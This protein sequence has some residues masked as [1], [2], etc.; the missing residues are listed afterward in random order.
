VQVSQRQRR[1]DRNGAIAAGTIACARCDTPVAIGSDQVAVT[2][3]LT[4]PFCTPQRPV[5]E[6]RSLDVPTR[7]TRVQVR[8]RIRSVG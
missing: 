8:L 4:C 3:A 1:A 6:F 7:P 5:G 2:E